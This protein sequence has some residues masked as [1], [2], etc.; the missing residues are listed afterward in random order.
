MVFVASLCKRE[1]VFV[2]LISVFNCACIE[3]RLSCVLLFVVDGC[4]CGIFFI[5]SQGVCAYVLLLLL[6]TQYRA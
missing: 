5:V 2:L 1:G 4:N 6:F 3:R